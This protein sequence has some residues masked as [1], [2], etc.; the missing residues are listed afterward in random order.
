MAGRTR[1]LWGLGLGLL[2]GACAGIGGGDPELYT[3][4]SDGDVAL[5]AQ[6]LQDTLERAPDGASRQWRNAD[7]GH[8]GTITPTRT[9]LSETGDYCRDYRE[10]LIVGADSGRFLHVA[11]RDDGAHWVWL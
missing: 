3:R 8:A 7:T 5:A 6:T 4:L 2:L 1:S 11:C 9:W 10:E